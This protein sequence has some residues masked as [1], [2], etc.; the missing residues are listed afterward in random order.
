MG[1]RKGNIAGQPA[2]L[3]SRIA[4]RQMLDLIG[5]NKFN[6]IVF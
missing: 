4:M 6:L 3:G 1:T 5:P 2:V